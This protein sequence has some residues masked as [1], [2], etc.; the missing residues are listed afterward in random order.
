MGAAGALVN[1]GTLMLDRG[2]PE[3]ARAYLRESLALH[4]ELR[5][6]DGIAYCLEGTAGVLV[7]AQQ[8]EAA[9]E[10]ARL[11]GAAT[12]LRRSLN[13]P[14]SPTERVRNDRDRAC[15]R[16]TLGPTR[17]E[18]AQSEGERLSM[19]QAVDHA[20]RLLAPKPGEAV[21]GS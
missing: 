13:V 3:R 9:W 14:L 5:E 6:K 7:A 21:D 11:L 2:E 10:A 15:A 4:W 20:M 12:A 16:A 1:L 18:E 8:P 19:A 17:Y